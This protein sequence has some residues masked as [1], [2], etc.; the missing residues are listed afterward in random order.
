[1]QFYIMT[2]QLI[3]QI[4]ITYYAYSSDRSQYGS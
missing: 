3:R 4:L 2:M 1:M